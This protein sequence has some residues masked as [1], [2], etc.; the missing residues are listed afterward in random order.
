MTTNRRERFVRW[1]V[2]WMVGTVL[3]L[4]LVGSLT[5]E[6]FF[7]GSLIGLLVLSVF[8]TPLNVTPAW[9]TRLRWLIVGGLFVFG[10]LVV[11]YLIDIV[12]WGLFG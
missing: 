9:R 2:A 4:A 3:A 10:F 8:V 5:L 6:I 1:Q 11:R 7:V 12:P